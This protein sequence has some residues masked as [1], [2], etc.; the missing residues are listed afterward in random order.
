MVLKFTDILNILKNNPAKQLLENARE[1]SKKLSMHV[2]G[3]E[4]TIKRSDFF[5]NDEM[6]TEQKKSMISNRDLFA[7]VLQQEDMVFSSQGGGYSFSV[8]DNEEQR[9]RDELSNIRYGMSL[10]KW[11]RNF[12]L[13]AYRVDP[14]GV[15]LMETEPA[16]V[17]ASGQISMSRVYPVYKSTSSI[18]D[19]LTTGRNLEYIVFRLKAG[20]ARQLG[21]TDEK[22]TD[23]SADADTEYY[24]IIDDIRDVLV[25]YSGNELRELNPNEVSTGNPIKLGWKKVPAFIV[26]DL[27]W[28][29]KPGQFVSPIEN[30][31]EL[32]DTFIYDRSVRELQ[33]K[34]HGFAKAVEPLLKCSTCM[35]SG[36]VDGAPCKDCTPPGKT[37]GTGYKFKTKVADVARFPIENMENGFDF[38]KF[39]GYVTPDIE[40]WKQ[41]DLSL[42]E[43]EELIEMTYWGTVK[44]K[45]THNKASGEPITATESD[46]NEAPK[47]ARLNMTADW[48]ESTENAIAWFVGK[49]YFKDNF[50]GSS[51]TVGRDFIV[52]SADQLMIDYLNLIKSN[53]PFFMCSET[54]E[55][56]YMAKYQKNPLQMQ[57]YLKKLA[58]EPFPHTGINT[59]KSIISDPSIINQKMFFSEWELTVPTTDWLKKK[60]DVLREELKKYVEAK[61][62]AAPEQQPAVV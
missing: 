61:N 13:A 14:M 17:N 25:F 31:V 10:R 27:M 50:K 54:L 62:I 3:V 30:I 33:K 46:N 8:G 41:Q 15:I 20:Q 23:M 40:S 36:L 55:R 57:V 35:G 9:L 21:I 24:R 32:A 56:Y 2:L 11:V 38:K 28:F 6:Y 45:K 53:A 43:L 39:F 19:Y 37:I 29:D 47:I 12:A 7:R 1:K 58:V 4:P 26:S 16:K 34:M 49:F 52:K 5:A 51:I 42:E 59:L 44:I 18:Y 60:P 22:L 48:V